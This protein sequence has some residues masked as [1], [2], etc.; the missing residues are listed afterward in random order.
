MANIVLTRGDEGDGTFG[1]F[2]GFVLRPLGGPGS[3]YFQSSYPCLFL[4]E[5]PHDSLSH[6]PRLP[7]TLCPG[8]T[9]PPISV[10][11]VVVPPS[12][13]M[14]STMILV[15]VSHFPQQVHTRAT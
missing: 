11:V 15:R 5:Q 4:L 12:L 10:H 2:S 7:L 9:F 3:P 14:P 13:T 8:I 6:P 1:T